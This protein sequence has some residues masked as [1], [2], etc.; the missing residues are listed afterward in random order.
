MP[1]P[2]RT[3][4]VYGGSFNPPHNAHRQVAE[5][6]ANAE[7]IDSVWIVPAYQHAFDKPLPE[8]VHRLRMCE[9][10]F[11]GLSNTHVLD[12]EQQL[13]GPS[14]MVRTLEVLQQRHP[15][16]QLRLVIGS[17][18]VHQLDRWSQPE[19]I[20]T[21]APLWIVQRE[22]NE[23]DGVSGPV[24][25]AIS[26]TDIR[27]RIRRGEDVGHCVP[28]AVVDYVAAQGLYREPEPRP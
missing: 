25:P 21:L 27:Q 5:H 9:H 13:G 28:R 8:F 2:R 22:G 15:D 23:I 10:A 4:A 17:D 14:L 3:V 16:V 19:R 18:L 1:S 24:F 11:A 7:G 6:V 26:S 20:R 12:I